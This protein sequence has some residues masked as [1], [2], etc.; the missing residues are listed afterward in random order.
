MTVISNYG[1]MQV[2]IATE[3]G[4]RTDLLFPPSLGTLP[5]GLPVP[6]LS[7]IQSAIQNAIAKWE[8]THF[9]FNELQSL[10]TFSTVVGQEFYVPTTP[11]LTWDGGGSW[12]AGTS[13][14]QTSGQTSIL[15]TTI[16]I[17]KIWVLVSSNRYSLNPRTEQYM[18][19]TSL[20]PAVQGQPIDYSYYAGTLRLYPIPDGAYPISIE[21][22]VRFSP[23]QD[24]ADS[25]AWTQDAEALIRTEAKL[26]ILTNIL[27]QPDLAAEQRAMIYGSGSTDHSYLYVLMQEGVQRPAVL[28]M[29]A[30]YF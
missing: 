10:N 23:L 4:Y 3:L 17:D 15:G 16:H 27:K 5:T 14:D 30:M 25:N 2:Q 22:T 6:T 21:G 1:Q 8:R 24:V 19:D 26:D 13:W 29:R 12:D 11:P 7:P 18:S 9:Y 20:N 28:K